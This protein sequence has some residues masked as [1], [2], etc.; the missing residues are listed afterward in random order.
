M[1][2]QFGRALIFLGVAMIIVGALVWIGGRLGLGSL[3]GDFRLTGERWGCYI[4][5][6]SSLIIS[7]VLTLLLNLLFRLFK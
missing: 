5:L 6:V 3:P 4:P 2:Q 7:V 1:F